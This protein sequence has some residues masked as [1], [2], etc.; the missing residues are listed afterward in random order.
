[1]GAQEFK[2]LRKFLQDVGRDF[3]LQRRFFETG[4]ETFWSD[5]GVRGLLHRHGLGKLNPEHQALFEGAEPPSLAEIQ[6]ALANEPDFE[7]QS[8]FGPSWALVRA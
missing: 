5:E 4:R 8:P 3:D 7:A 1:M 2:P 6:E